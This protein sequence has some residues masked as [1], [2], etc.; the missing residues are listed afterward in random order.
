ML[1]VNSVELHTT[2]ILQIIVMLGVILMS[3]TPQNVVA[4]LGRWLGVKGFNGRAS[5][6]NRALD[7]S[8]YPG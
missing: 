1:S 8:T 3:I 7:G 2:V 4:P 6:V 5:A